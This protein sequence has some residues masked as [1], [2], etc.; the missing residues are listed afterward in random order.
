MI[1]SSPATG[2]CLRDAMM[3][4]KRSG[5][6]ANGNDDKQRHAQVLTT[7][8]VT[9]F[10]SSSSNKPSRMGDHCGSIEWSSDTALG[11]SQ[12]VLCTTAGSAWLTPRI[13]RL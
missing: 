11:V 10:C 2:S 7:M 1:K 13:L 9:S 4:G 8:S 3:G 6:L 5:S 12:G